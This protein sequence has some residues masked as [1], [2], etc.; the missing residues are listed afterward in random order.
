MI[1]KNAIKLPLAP[2]ILIFMP[3]SSHIIMTPNASVKPKWIKIRTSQFNLVILCMDKLRNLPYEMD[4]FTP[5]PPMGQKAKGNF[6]QN[7]ILCMFAGIGSC[8]TV[9]VNSQTV[10]L[11]DKKKTVNL[12]Y[13]DLMNDT[14]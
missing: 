12:L 8:A 9:Y 13:Y 14:N 1:K 7:A 4:R 2:V 10:V 3:S 11:S 5:P 6:C